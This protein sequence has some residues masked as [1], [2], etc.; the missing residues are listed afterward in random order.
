MQVERNAWP[1]SRKNAQRAAH[2]KEVDR[3]S[4]KLNDEPTTVFDFQQRR[5]NCDVWINRWE[6]L[7]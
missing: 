7:C 3:V 4:A 1:E 5:S 2:E 6:K